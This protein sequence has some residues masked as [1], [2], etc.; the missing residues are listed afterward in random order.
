MATNDSGGAPIGRIRPVILSGG[1]GTRLWP[2]SRQ[3]WPKQLLPLTGER[4]LLQMTALRTGDTGRYANPVVVTHERYAQ[5]V[6]GQLASVGIA[7]DRIILEPAAR[8]TAPAIALAAFHADPSD[9]L[10]VMPSDHSI[11]DVA[12]FQEALDK[13][14]A[15][16]RHGWLITLGLT[17]TRAETGYGYIR[18]GGAL[19]EGIWQVEKFVEKPAEALAR[20]YLESGDYLWNGGIFVF[21]AASFLAEL[22]RTAPD[23]HAAT[24]RAVEEATS[25]GAFLAPGAESFRSAPSISVDYAVLEKA[26]RVA[27]VPVEMGW[28]DVG[29]WDA[30]L[31]LRAPDSEG[32][33]LSGD[34]IISDVTGC[35]ITAAG[36]VVAAFG[37]SDLTIVATGDTVLIMPAGRSDEIKAIVAQLEARN[38]TTLREW[39]AGPLGQLR[40][41]SDKARLE[42]QGVDG[43]QGVNGEEVVSRDGIVRPAPPAPRHLAPPES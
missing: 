11:A 30:L 36:P 5:Q 43:G 29:S 4:T 33:R 2:L 16:A 31:E 40:R 28:S 19:D 38:C 37:V 25:S 22:E 39:P 13:A 17:P 3:D 9:V 8:N 23:V 27:V 41:K 32:N 6:L 42:T 12:A 7:P 15:F 20:A 21:T 18:R 10:V 26:E 35:A 34:V 24:K 1:S 14:V